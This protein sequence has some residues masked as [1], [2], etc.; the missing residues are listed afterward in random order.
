MFERLTVLP[1]Y[2]YRGDNRRKN[3]K[4][5]K[6][7]PLWKVRSGKFAGWRT[8]D[9]FYDENGSHVGY[10]S[11]DVAYSHDG[12]YIGEIYRNDWIGYRTDK[13]PSVS[14]E[15]TAARTSI[16]VVNPH[17]NRSGFSISG[18]DDPIY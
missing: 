15:R 3:H 1:V 9:D 2:W 10:F 17:A 6:M 8:G 13:V 7:N 5:V 18:W 12:K 11:D 16:E 4:E 14:K